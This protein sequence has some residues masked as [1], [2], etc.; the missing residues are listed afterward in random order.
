MLKFLTNVGSD[1][2]FFS[3]II[4]STESFF[5]LHF[6][7]F[8][9]DRTQCENHAKNVWQNELFSHSNIDPYHSS[10]SVSYFKCGEFGMWCVV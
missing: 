2:L 7:H 5:L 9:S 6:K 3:L 1:I 4:P 10:V 8:D